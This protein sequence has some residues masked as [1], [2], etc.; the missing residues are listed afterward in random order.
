[1]KIDR[2]LISPFKG[3]CSRFFIENLDTEKCQ[4]VRPKLRCNH[5]PTE[6]SAACIPSWLAVCWISSIKI[7]EI[8]TVAPCYV[9]SNLISRIKRSGLRYRYRFSL[10]PCMGLDLQSRY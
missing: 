10:T 3:M 8:L 1:M 4:T 9:A 2:F 6:F 7:S 5:D